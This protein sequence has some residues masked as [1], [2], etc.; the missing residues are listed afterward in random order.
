MGGEEEAVELDLSPPHGFPD[1]QR[2]ESWAMVRSITRAFGR[3]DPS[4]PVIT[5]PLA[6]IVA[7]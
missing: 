1:A 2:R 7:V 6:L 3:T 4:V 5:E